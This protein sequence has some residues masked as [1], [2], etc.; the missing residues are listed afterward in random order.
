MS[1]PPVGSRPARA[2][3]LLSGVALG[4]LLALLL[5]RALGVERGTVVVLTVGALPVV[6]LTAWPLLLLAALLRA[7][8]LSALA[9]VAVAGQ[10]VLVLP[11]LGAARL[12]AGA[13][14]APR[15]RVVTA[16]LYVGNRE[17][18]AAGVAL[19]ALHP[20]VLVV[21]E[22]T[23][24]GLAGLRAGG[25][26]DDLPHAAY[27]LTG[28]PESVGLFSRLP[29]TD[30]VLHP[31]GTRVLPR[32]TVLVGGRRVRILAAHTLPPFLTWE[33]LWRAGLVDLRDEARHEPLPL[34][35]AGDFNAD[36]DHAPFRA[37]LS[38]GLRDAHDERGR[39]LVRTWPTGLPLLQLDHVLVRDGAGA[40]IAVRAVREARVEGSDH[41][42][43]V[44]DLAVLA[45]V[46]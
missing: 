12:P 15:L 20:D 18:S 16:N 13:S 4:A 37:L 39:G 3:R 40:R 6:L 17:P 30:V 26:L 45:P 7:R 24:A 29:L 35:M 9:V 25:L 38:A 2:A 33:G 8:L 43:V 10:V 28:R 36:R 44:A 27:D 14:T 19:R 34:V 11:G 46:R 41:E 42:A 32:A 1:P 5:V 22:L 31:I 21:P 23:P